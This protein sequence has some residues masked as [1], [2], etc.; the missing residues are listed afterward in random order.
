MHILYITN[1]YTRTID[2]N[3]LERVS[4][5]ARWGERVFVCVVRDNASAPT[6]P[7]IFAHVGIVYIDRHF[8]PFVTSWRIKKAC[9][10]FL[11]GAKEYVNIIADDPEKAGPYARALALAYKSDYSVFAEFELPCGINRSTRAL[12]R[13]LSEARMIVVPSMRVKKSCDECVGKDLSALVA[14][15]PSF[16]KVEECTEKKPDRYAEGSMVF[17]LDAEGMRT[18]DVRVALKGFAP[19]ARRYP[20]VVL[21]VSG[22]ARI[23]EETE[24]FIHAESLER[25]MICLPLLGDK[26]RLR[27]LVYADLVLYT[28]EKAGYGTA[29]I[30]ALLAGVPALTTDVGVVGS[31]VTTDDALICPPGDS[32]CLTK[33]MLLLLD[34]PAILH[35]LKEAAERMK[36]KFPRTVSEEDRYD[37]KMKD[38]L[39]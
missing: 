38:L 20:N 17:F 6:L 24:H 16:V 11:E 9:A 7:N 31:L 23:R 18:E 26:E 36:E 33:R 32:A 39:E 35:S 8:F 5:L 12:S 19:V 27:Y 2:S 37:L 14:I 4:R 15:V 1:D 34:N 3:L 25:N 13:V 28:P 29:L 10:P 30:R 21:A 22:C